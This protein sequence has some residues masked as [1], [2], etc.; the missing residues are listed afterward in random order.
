M[1]IQL[2]DDK[3]RRLR[4]GKIHTQTASLRNVIFV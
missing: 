1:N 3:R 2:T 4:I